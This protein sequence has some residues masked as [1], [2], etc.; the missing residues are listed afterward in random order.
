MNY[1]PNRSV[2]VLSAFV[3]SFLLGM[4][5]HYFAV[6]R[7]LNG[8]LMRSEIA[9]QKLRGKTEAGLLSKSDLI[10][11]INGFINLYDNCSKA[12]ELNGYKERLRKH[13]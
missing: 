7:D 11:K 6:A 5:T 4:L 3:V 8:R 2:C 1:R 10:D 9:I 13:E 12:G